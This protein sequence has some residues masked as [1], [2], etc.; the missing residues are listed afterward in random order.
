MTDRQA[1][2]ANQAAD[3]FVRL[4]CDDV[5][6]ADLAEWF[7]WCSHPN[8]LREFRR[9]RD[10]W[11]GFDQLHA[12]AAQL[13]DDGEDSAFHSATRQGWRRLRRPAAAALACAAVLGI[14]IALGTRWVAPTHGI[15][16]TASTNRSTMLPDGSTLTLAPRTQIGVD[17][18]GPTRSLTLSPGE[19]YF[20]VRPDKTKPFVVRTN[21]VTVTAVGTAFDVRS[22]TGHAVVTVQEGI[23][24]VVG[25]GS[26]TQ[27][28]GAWRVSAGY[29]V[30][31]DTAS[32]EV[33]LSAID[34]A[35]AFDWRDGRL[36]YF[37]ERLDAI[38]AD[39][40]RY[41]ERPIKVADPAI[42][43]L[44]FTGTIFTESID[45]WLSAIQ[46]TFAICAVVTS[47]NRVL[48]I[49]NDTDLRSAFA[50]Q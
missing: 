23:V 2:C 25:I 13:L 8:N 41:S 29:Q 20:K 38:V 34:A 47:D 28:R 49:G 40:N 10:V 43:R 45:D 46:A 24:N 22:E 32:R 3:W 14:G 1:A 44:R 11:T 16:T 27:L 7:A 35:H 12:E 33:R 18:S 26:G 15:V 36:Q 39:V 21:E 17:F 48:L 9:I 19:A 37:D 31:Y 6:E 4:S 42:G 5:S 50:V 30:V